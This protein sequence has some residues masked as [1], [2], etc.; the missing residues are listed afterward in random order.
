MPLKKENK[1][2][3]MYVLNH[4]FGYIR[5]QCTQVYIYICFFS[6]SDTFIIEIPFIILHTAR[7]KISYC[8]LN[9][10]FIHCKTVANY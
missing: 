4:I 1:I 9:Y 3:F 5:V 7:F 6:Y 10:T 8:L 2:V